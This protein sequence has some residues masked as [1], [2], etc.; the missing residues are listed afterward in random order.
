MK[1]S[2]FIF[3]I[4]RLPRGPRRLGAAMLGW[5]MVVFVP[6][7][8]KDLGAQKGSSP[9]QRFWDVNFAPS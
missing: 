6:R 4:P 1:F 3:L 8:L 7:W 2:K 9:I 5:S